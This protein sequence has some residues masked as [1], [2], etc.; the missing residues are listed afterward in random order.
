MV[1]SCKVNNL[2]YDE[3]HATMTGRKIK[4]FIKALDE[5]E[6]FEELDTNLQIKAY[7]Q[8]VMMYGGLMVT[9]SGLVLMFHAAHAVPW[10][11]NLVFQETR[12][13]LLQ[14]VRIVN[15]KQSELNI[16]DTVSDTSYAWRVMADYVDTIHARVKADPATVVL[17]RATFLKL[18]S[19]LD[20]PLIRIN[21]CDS[22]DTIS[23]AQYYSSEMVEFLRQ[24]RRS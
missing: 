5:V 16:M 8:V 6:Q 2:S 18:A 23:V 4:E 9:S 12:D 3:E 13:F 19:M 7:L 21:Q 20:V 15:L 11:G 10:C 24:A 22:P 17:L 14:I 1:L